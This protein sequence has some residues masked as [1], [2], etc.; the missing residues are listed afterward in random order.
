VR[1]TKNGEIHINE[2]SPYGRIKKPFNDYETVVPMA[3][4]AAKYYNDNMSPRDPFR[5][6]DGAQWTYIAATPIDMPN[7]VVFPKRKKKNLKAEVIAF[8]E[9]DEIENFTLD[10]D[11]IIEK[12]IHKKLESVYDTLGWDIKNLA[13]SKPM[14]W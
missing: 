1:K 13:A 4:R 5:Q 10:Y 11:I 7:E 14:E 12:M 6:G 3:V 2:L 8:R 9:A